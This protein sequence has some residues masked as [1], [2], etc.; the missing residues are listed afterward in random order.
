MRKNG[1]I[2]LSVVTSLISILCAAV[3]YVISINSAADTKQNI[4][5]FTA[6][7]RSEAA[8]EL[9]L[10]LLVNSADGTYSLAYERTDAGFVIVPELSPMLFDLDDDFFIRSISEEC[11]SYLSSAG[12]TDI[13]A[14]DITVRIDA[15]SKDS[16]RLGRFV[17]DYDFN[18]AQGEVTAILPD[19]TV[20]LSSG[21]G[22]GA[23]RET[24][25]ISGITITRAAFNS[26]LDE[27]IVDTVKA[28]TDCS[29][30]EITITDYQSY[31]GAEDA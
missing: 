31:G 12:Y 7:Y 22:Y 16:L 23:V 5:R 3:L 17:T 6:Q 30:A 4:R 19:I 10:G 15:D 14:K 28:E 25:V 9:A 2:Q 1:N 24:A 20:E 11:A 8:M 21:Y 27:G 29:A 26:A 18:T 13:E